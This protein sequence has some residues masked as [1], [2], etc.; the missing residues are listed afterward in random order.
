MPFLSSGHVFARLLRAI[1]PASALLSAGRRSFDSVPGRHDHAARVRW[2]MTL[3][4]WSAGLP[5]LLLML[6]AVP[7][8]AL[9]INQADARQL[10]TLKGIGPSM[11]ERILAERARGGFHD[12]ED[13]ASRVK[14]VGAARIRQWQGQGAT[15]SPPGRAALTERGDQAA[16][17]GRSSPSASPARAASAPSG[18]RITQH[19]APAGSRSRHRDAPS[20]VEVIEGG[21]RSRRRP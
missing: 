14:G 16:S 1:R 4:R 19:K 2:R 6:A 11:A 3:F 12:F 18:A 17:A 10:Q 8:W 13:L 15:V 21:L 5:Y 9:D 20:A 7:A